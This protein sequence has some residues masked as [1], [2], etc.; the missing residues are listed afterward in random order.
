M[1]G[2]PLA[3]KL[4]G[5]LLRNR[6]PPPFL[7]WLAEAPAPVVL[8]PGGGAAADAVRH[9]QTHHDFDDDAAH[10]L[11]VRA[12]GLTAALWGELLR[13]P[14]AGGFDECRSLWAAGVSRLVLDPG[15]ELR[16]EPT[17]LPRGWAVTSDSI[18]AWA[19]RRLAATRLVLCKSVGPPASRADAVVRGWLDPGFADAAGDLPVEWLNAAAPTLLRDLR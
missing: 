4:G 17:A 12:L 9:W 13:V 8:L 6:L 10:W 11:A 2:G 19:A 3:L 14:V 5:S 15:P 16:A 7:S 18:A 1:I